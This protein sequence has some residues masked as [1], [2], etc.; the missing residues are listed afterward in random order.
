MVITGGSRGIGAASATLL[1]RRGYDV[2]IAYRSAQREADDVVQAVRGLGR[3]A[4][5]LRVDVTQAEEAERLMRF[6]A[7]TCGPITALVNSAGIAGRRSPLVDLLP[8]EILE[9]V[10]VNLLGT[11]YCI[12][13]GLKHMAR[14]QGGRGGAIVNVS[15]DAAR[16]GGNRLAA[17][18]AA[19]AGVNV[20]T[21]ALAREI[22]AEGLRVNAVAPGIVRTEQYAQEDDAR[23]ADI[24]RGIPLLRLGTPE[25]VAQAIAWLLSDDASYVTGVVLPVHGG[26]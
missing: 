26:R 21:T 19:K 14:S 4:A 12:H 20:L 1:A 2:C 17:Y 23:L 8:A 18:A 9:V 16:T 22:G 6:A 3:K 24:A 10:S 5:A 11:I 25:E 13:A 7:E 15:S